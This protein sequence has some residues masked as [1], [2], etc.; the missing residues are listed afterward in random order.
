MTLQWPWRPPDP[1]TPVVLLDFDGVVNA[2]CRP[3]RVPRGYARHTV[4]LDGATWPDHEWILPLIPSS[5]REFTVTLNPKNSQF[6]KELL[7]S[8]VFVA[9]ATTWQHAV[10][11][12]VADNGFPALP[13]LPIDRMHRPG[14]RFH[15]TTSWKLA[16][17]ATFDKRTP[18][19]FVDDS[20]GGCHSPTV[21]AHGGSLHV[22][23]PRD[24]YGLTTRDRNAIRA[25]ANRQLRILSRTSIADQAARVAANPR[26]RAETASV[27]TGMETLDNDLD[28]TRDENR[29][30]TT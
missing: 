25:W 8:G 19:L 14:E 4:W 7:E 15:D 21:G 9:W 27:L 30:S 28:N 22:I 3:P 24:S 1:L 11:P 17:F 2:L 10:L 12:V 13:V 20:A 5:G 18:L 6:V 16:A 23:V 29:D 26:D